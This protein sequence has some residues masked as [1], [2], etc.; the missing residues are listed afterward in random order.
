MDTSALKANASFSIRDNLE[1]DAKVTD[2]SDAHQQKDFFEIIS[3]LEGIQIELKE[4][5]VN[6]HFSIRVN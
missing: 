2:V 1:I 3:T 6:A 5:P 4:L